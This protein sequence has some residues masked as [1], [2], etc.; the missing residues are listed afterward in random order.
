MAILILLFNDFLLSFIIF[1][2]YLESQEEKLLKLYYSGLNRCK[3]WR[4]V[5]YYDL[6]KY[7]FSFFCCSDS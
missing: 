2:Q 1:S 6:L 4:G 7:V 5:A 3:L